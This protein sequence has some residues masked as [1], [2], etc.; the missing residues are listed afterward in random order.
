MNR[1]RL[2]LGTLA[3]GF[4]GK[5]PVLLGL[6]GRAPRVDDFMTPRAAALVYDAAL[7]SRS[8]EGERL[9]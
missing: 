2:V 3:Q 6:D 8:A 9:S 5:L 1:L 7:R 4:R